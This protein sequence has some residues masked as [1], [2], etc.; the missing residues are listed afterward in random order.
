MLLELFK[1]LAKEIH[2]FNVFN[3]ITLRAVMAT[4]TSLVISFAFGPWLIK[5]LNMSMS[6]PMP[7][8]LGLM[9]RAPV[10]ERWAPNSKVEDE[11][12]RVKPGDPV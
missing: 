4:I 7:I 11:A 12:G 1:F 3:Y 10:F 8:L 2:G 9:A 6:M 5:K